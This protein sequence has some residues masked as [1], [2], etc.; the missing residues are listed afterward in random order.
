[1]A[2]KERDPAV[3]AYLK[4]LGRLGGAARDRALTPRQKKRIAKLGGQAFKESIEKKM[5]PA[6]RSA[7]MA[8]LARKRWAAVRAAKKRKDD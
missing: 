6:Q 3:D 2:R 1:M 4:M 5:T 8:K 7:R